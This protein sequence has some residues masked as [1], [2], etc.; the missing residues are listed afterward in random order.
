MFSALTDAPQYCITLQPTEFDTKFK[1]VGGKSHPGGCTK[2]PA[3]DSLP[4]GLCL[5]D[6]ESETCYGPEPYMCSLPDD[7]CTNCP[8]Q[9]INTSQPFCN[10]CV[11][12]VTSNTNLWVIFHLSSAHIMRII[13]SRL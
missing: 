9:C 1:T 4:I 6:D 12:I 8:G 13:G 10:N 11:W 2:C 7:S 3:S 5:P